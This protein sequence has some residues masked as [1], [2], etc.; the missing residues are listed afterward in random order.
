MIWN[1]ELKT[2]IDGQIHQPGK[3]AIEAKLFSEI[4]RKLPDNDITIETDDQY[5]ATITC[6]KAC[7]QIMGQEGE[8]FPSLPEIEKNSKYHFIPVFFKRSDSSKQFFRFRI[9]KIRN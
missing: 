9:M 8:E 4:V 5:K 7:F 1:L 2:T 6:E 3:I